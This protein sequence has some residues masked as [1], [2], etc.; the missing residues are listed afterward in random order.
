MINKIKNTGSIMNPFE[1]LMKDIFSN[2]DFLEECKI[3]NRSYSCICSAYQTGGVS[4]TD[5]GMESE[6]N[7]SLDIKLP[8]DRYPKINDK[9][10]FREKKYKISNITTDSANQSIKIYLIALSKGV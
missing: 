6:Q 2:K 10:T 4:Y 9:L 5:A 1:K 3:E 7:F 8:I